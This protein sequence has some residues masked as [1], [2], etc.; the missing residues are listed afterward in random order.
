[1]ASGKTYGGNW[2]TPWA[3]R[4]ADK[5]EPIEPRY[6]DIELVVEDAIDMARTVIECTLEP[7]REMLA[8]LPAAINIDGWRSG[9][10]WRRR[11][12]FGRRRSWRGSVG[13]DA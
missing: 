5:D 8:T 12:R 11:G 2:S 9:R 10:S 1:M 13:W 4:V 3:D 6:V 7:V